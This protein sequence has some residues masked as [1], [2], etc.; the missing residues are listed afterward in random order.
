MTTTPDPFA[1]VFTRE[2]M[3]D[4]ILLGFTGADE[5]TPAQVESTVDQFMIGPF[6]PLRS[7]RTTI[8]DEVLRRVRVRVG[9][10]STLD[11]NRGHEEWLPRLDRSDWRLWPRLSEY[12]RQVSRLP[13]T[14]LMELDRST[15][16]TLERIESPLREGRWDRR[17]LVVGHVQSGKTTHY[18]SVIAKALDAGYQIVI[19][20]AGIHK[21]LR[22]QTHER[23][24]TD[25]I[26]LDSAALLEAARR[27]ERPP[28]G[29]AVVG[30]GRFDLQ[31]GLGDLPFTI[32]TCTT[33]ADDGD[34]RTS[35]ARQI[36]FRVSPGTRLVMVVKKN[37]SI[38]TNLRDWLRA[39]NAA[40]G[41]TARI[42]A[43]AL[44]IDDEA[45]HASI[46]TNDPEEDPTTI[47]RLI[48]EL[49]Q[50]FERVGFVGYTA[51]PFANIFIPSASADGPFGD[52]LFPRSFV[53]NLKAP[54]DYIGPALVFGHPGDESVG[55]P[56]QLPLPMHVSVTDSSAWLPDGHR[57]GH[58]PGPLPGSL[59]EALRLFALVCASRVVRGQTGEHST[60]LV[61]ATRFINVQERVAQQI[62]EEVSTLRNVAGL[63]GRNTVEQL[64][65]AFRD[66]WYRHLQ[67]HHAAFRAALGD[68]C[69]PLPD[70]ERVWQEV[71]AA[72]NRIRIM[73]VNGDSSDA[74]A[75]SRTPDGLW[76]IAIG[77][78]K[79]SRGL[80]L[81]GLSVS[82]F[83]RT[84]KMFDTLMQMGRWFGYRPG[85]ADLCRVF[86]T[87]SLHVAFRQIALA[88]DD[89]RADL[90]RMA[91]ARKT[92]E[93]FGLRVRTPSDG[94]LITAANKL[95]DGEEVFVRFAGEL[96]QA[97]EIPRT[98]AQADA[99][100]AAVR[101][102]I[103]RLGTG[104]TQDVRGRQSSHFLW[105]DV[106]VATVLEFLERYEAISTPSF[107]GRCEALRRYIRERATQGELRT[108][109]VAVI[110]RGN[111]PGSVTCAGIT[112]PLVVRSA[113]EDSAIPPDR[114]A[115]EAV[116]GSADEAADLGQTEYDRATAMSPP[117]RDR[118]NDRPTSPARSKVR[119]VR[120][121]SGRGYLMLYLIK[122]PSITDP[123]E[124]IPSAAISFPESATAQPLAYTVNETWR[125][126][127][128]LF[129]E[130]VINAD[131]S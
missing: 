130:E 100:R 105:H 20:L 86:T 11:D 13:P 79:L 112:F 98:G 58:V 56:A 87:D 32:L 45:D 120:G 104:Y 34:F 6:S 5:P 131:A 113:R 85:Y 108:W 39:Q 17:G 22:S 61:H 63:G 49:L 102:L 12:L 126:E 68:R 73:K 109:T 103:E 15:D 54:T 93:E 114:F 35:I 101:T 106:P 91:D 31:R 99:N 74:L 43:P 125:R 71:P 92:P 28:A 89:L 76:V 62:E 64:R 40:P 3:L 30:V 96:V 4:M 81:A 52:D 128:G 60:M 14:V 41:A 33:S 69:E 51:T 80:T 78:D 44:V 67:R 53:V 77:G 36:G 121:A 84:S 117:P 26:G 47:N 27:G 38:L 75:Y 2:R 50:S 82:Y 111:S 119:E 70:F 8:I 83:L 16:Q 21:S 110:S 129:D 94:L 57:N 7:Q 23:L 1:G 59:R 19:V 66:I 10:A 116:V 123:V 88:M 29:A 37:R 9:A 127:Y 122:D 97:L 55:L 25:L 95:R 118:P 24:D 107:F 18:T 65:T 42:H 72:L 115:T 124:F 48:R 46:N 90:D